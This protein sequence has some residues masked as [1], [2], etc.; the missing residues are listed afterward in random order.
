MT[1]YSVAR[2]SGIVTDVSDDPADRSAYTGPDDDGISW[3]VFP[4]SILPEVL[5]RSDTIA[6]LSA[7]GLTTAVIHRAFD[8]WS[9]LQQA[10][11]AGDSEAFCNAVLSTPSLGEHA[12]VQDV[13]EEPM[14]F[15]YAHTGRVVA[16]STHENLTGRWMSGIPHQR[17]PAAIW[18]L[19]CAAMDLGRAIAAHVP[20]A[21]PL[22]SVR[23]VEVLLLPVGTTKHRRRLM[24]I[25]GYTRMI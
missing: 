9:A 23:S 11:S 1:R 19:H 16:A 22:P 20:Y 12:I 5:P 14:D 17:S 21:G 15:R 8:A 4:Y 10:G 2:G 6:T 13:R 24:L 25:L 18:Q 3:R 7:A